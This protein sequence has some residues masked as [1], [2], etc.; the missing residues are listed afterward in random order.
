M[1]MF[2]SIL[3]MLSASARLPDALQQTTVAS[4]GQ[5]QTEIV[6]I[7]RG[8]ATFTVATNMP[9]LS[10]KGKSDALHVRAQIRREPEGLIFEH[11]EASLQVKTLATGIALRDQHMREYVFRTSN[12]EVPD[13]HFEA[14]NVPC[15]G[16]VPTREATCK[17]AGSLNIRGI[18]R[19]FSIRLKIREGNPNP[20]FRAGGD[21][22]VKLSDYGIEP[23]TQFGVKTANEIQIHIEIPE[24][25]ASANTAGG[26]Q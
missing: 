4:E 7:E 2:S 6:V 1:R 22:L 24:T 13:M 11:I 16:V 3:L 19:D 18:P 14:A 15:P 17:V 5:G 9:G 23:P 26:N 21:G 10:V 8:K 12:G 25:S 20:V